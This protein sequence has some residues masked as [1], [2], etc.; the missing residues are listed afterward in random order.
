MAYTGTP[1]EIQFE[2]R[3]ERMIEK[4]RINWQEARSYCTGQGLRRVGGLQNTP[5]RHCRQPRRA[6]LDFGHHG[7]R[8]KMHQAAIS[9]MTEAPVHLATRIQRLPGCIPVLSN[10]VGQACQEQDRWLIASSISVLR[11]AGLRWKTHMTL[12]L[13]ARKYCPEISRARLLPMPRYSGF[14]ASDAGKLFVADFANQYRPSTRETLRTYFSGGTG[15][16]GYATH[17][18]FDHTGDVL[19][20][21][22][23]TPYNKSTPWDRD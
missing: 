14:L 21:Y 10:E 13:L 16:A 19:Q 17:T 15:F 3:L 1:A 18:D 12:V 4:K 11:P 9:L 23:R 6:G 22:M 20:L 2:Q 7:E 5:I 8:K